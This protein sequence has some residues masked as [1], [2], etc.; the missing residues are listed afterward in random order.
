MMMNMVSTL[1]PRLDLM[2]QTSWLVYG[3]DNINL[4]FVLAQGAI[5]LF[6]ILVIALI[7]LV[8]RQF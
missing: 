4:T 6:L 7:D 1:T 2:G 8:V 3:V 5:F